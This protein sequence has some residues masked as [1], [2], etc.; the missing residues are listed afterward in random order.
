MAVSNTES[1]PGSPADKQVNIRVTEEMKVFWD[2]AA[3]ARGVPLSEF[4]RDVVQKE[5]EDLLVCQHPQSMI[6]EY[7]WSSRCLKCG[8]RLR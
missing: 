6:L 3:D 5:A 2:K 7:P 8:T 4:I 1:T